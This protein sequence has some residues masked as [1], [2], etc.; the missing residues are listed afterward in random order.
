[1]AQLREADVQSAAMRPTGDP[2]S[3][4]VVQFK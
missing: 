1:M 4:A 3:K 2:A